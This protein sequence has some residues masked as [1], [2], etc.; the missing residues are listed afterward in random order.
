MC[1]IKGLAKNDEN[2]IVINISHI[3]AES[4]YEFIQAIQID[5]YRI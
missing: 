1:V 3:Q 2:L 5:H 4:L